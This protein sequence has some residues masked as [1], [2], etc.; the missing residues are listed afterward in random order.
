MKLY[1]LFSAFLLST[2]LFS[3]SSRVTGSS[4][5]SVQ[6]YSHGYLIPFEVRITVTGNKLEVFYTKPGM[7]SPF[8]ESYSITDNERNELF[9]YLKEI[10][11]LK[12]DIPEPERKTDAPV[13]KI[14]ADLNGSSREIDIGQL[15][16]I[17][18]SLTTL[19]TK[20]FDLASVYKPGWKKEIGFE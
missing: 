6:Y 2:L 15:S 13:T 18:Q 10:D 3:C 4:E 7:Q 16:A 9:D 11:F 19:K 1:I 12:M 17:P 5:N 20:I 8:D 14:K